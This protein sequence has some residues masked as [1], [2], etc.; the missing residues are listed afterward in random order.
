MLSPF[1]I[2]NSLQK[3]K[4]ITLWTQ[5]TY[6]GGLHGLFHFPLFLYPCTHICTHM[7][8]HTHARSHFED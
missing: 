2:E 6:G 1:F 8:M 7:H 5:Y 3:S 4:R